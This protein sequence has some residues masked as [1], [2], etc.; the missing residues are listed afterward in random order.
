M[1]FVVAHL[2]DPS[3]ESLRIAAVP[4]IAADDHIERPVCAGH[5]FTAPS[6]GGVTQVLQVAADFGHDTPAFETFERF[7]PTG[8]KGQPV[9]IVVAVG[10]GPEQDAAVGSAGCETTSVKPKSNT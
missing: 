4:P 3:A 2:G 6:G 1:F 8:S 5:R 10:T 9:E 7:F